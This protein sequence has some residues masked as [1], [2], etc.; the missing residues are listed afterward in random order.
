M[1]CHPPSQSYLKIYQYLWSLSQFWL[2]LLKNSVILT[3]SFFEITYLFI[4]TTPA[5]PFFC[6]ITTLGQS[7]SS[8]VYNS[9]DSYHQLPLILSCHFHIHFPYSFRMLFFPQSLSTVTSSRL[10][11]SL[12]N[13]WFTILL[14]LRAH[15]LIRF[16]QGKKYIAERLR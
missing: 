1:N 8:H 10:Q 6:Y 16:I 4:M 5:L 12:L 15:C 7:S 9:A 14:S 2:I 11:V 13:W 3:Y